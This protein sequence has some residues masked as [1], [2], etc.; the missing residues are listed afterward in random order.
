MIHSLFIS[1]YVQ[2]GY[3]GFE[4]WPLTFLLLL[5]I[6]TAI[7]DKR[8]FLV[9]L[10]IMTLCGLHLFFSAKI[11]D[12]H[13]FSAG[14]ERSVITTLKGRA[15]DD[16]AI[17]EYGNNILLSTREVNRRSGEVSTARGLVRVSYPSFIDL[18]AGDYILFEGKFNDYGFSSKR[19]RV[20]KRSTMTDFRCKMKDV[21]SSRFSRLK[22]INS[23]ES[24]LLLGKK[25]ET[26]SELTL[27]ARE[28]GTSYLLALSGMHISLF[29]FFISF[30]LSFI[31]GKR[32]ARL[33]SLSIMLLYV[34][35][36]GPKPS[37]VRALIFSFVLFLFPKL[38]AIE[39][40]FLSLCIHVAIIPES[41]LEVS[42]VYSYLSLSG[43]LGFGEVLKKRL[44]DLVYLPL[45]ILD[46]LSASVSALL[47]TIPFSFHIFGGYSLSSI[48][49]GPFSMMLIYFF[50]LLSILS[51]FIPSVEILL[52]HNYRL[53]KFI[54]EKGS[55]FGYFETLRPYMIMIFFIL[56]VFL[57][58]S[59]LSHSKGKK[60]CGISTIQV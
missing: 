8:V 18:Y 56:L 57:L 40:L 14:F 7:K 9:L 47:Y 48:I 10:I 2:A 19:V 13:S 51:F 52:V 46:S 53:L 36:I 4:V 60:R 34:F 15:L 37:L 31:L 50:M 12:R 33:V 25:N 26:D 22:E 21:I 24:L 43:L 42:A 20:M 23:L 11:L 55:S 41:I 58:S 45:F 49:T 59:I 5:P 28:S 39:A 54:L 38:K 30:L 35:I 27:L 17:G 32:N 6:K 44:D 1:L 16:G 3:F 29:S